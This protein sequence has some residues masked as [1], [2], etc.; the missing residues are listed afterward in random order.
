[1]RIAVVKGTG[2]RARTLA[3]FKGLGGRV[4]RIEEARVVVRPRDARKL[5]PADPKRQ[6]AD[7]RREATAD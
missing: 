2:Q 1:M 5:D 7:R 4:A 3:A 6:S